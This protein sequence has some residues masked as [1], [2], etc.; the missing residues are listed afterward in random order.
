MPRH[1]YSLAAEQDIREIT[2]TIQGDNPP[3]AEKWFTDLERKCRFLAEFP[4]AG[5]VRNDLI[6]GV[7][8]FAFGN[9]LIF[10]DI[11]DTGITILRVI[12]ARRDVSQA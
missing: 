10:Y 3:A 11:D 1:R 7:H 12:N 2:R 4:K 9:Y 5:R 8:A 6:P